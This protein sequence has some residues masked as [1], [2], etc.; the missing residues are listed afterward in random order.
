MVLML[1]ISMIKRDIPVD[2]N[3]SRQDRVNGTEVLMA[4]T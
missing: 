2:M 4:G 1:T 3:V